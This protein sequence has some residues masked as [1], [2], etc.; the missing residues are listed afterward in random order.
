MDIPSV[1]AAWNDLP[2]HMR[3][4]LALVLASP[5]LHMLLALYRK[6]LDES[7]LTLRV[8]ELLDAV[9]LQTLALQKI[10]LN[11]VRSFVEDL[12]SHLREIA[13]DHEEF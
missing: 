10:R 6:R 4:E 5:T 3:E 11:D 8:P 13:N 1:R 7:E 12:A 2:P 9:H